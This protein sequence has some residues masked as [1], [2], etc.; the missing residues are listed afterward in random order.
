M[1][2]EEQKAFG[3]LGKRFYKD[4]IQPHV[5]H[6]NLIGDVNFPGNQARKTD[7]NYMEQYPFL[8][9]NIKNAKENTYLPNNKPRLD[10]NGFD[11]LRVNWLGKDYAYQIKNSA[12]DGTKNFHNIKPYELLEKDNKG[13]IENLLESYLKKGKK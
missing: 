2:K 12:Y 3:R 5:E 6:N 8:R 13:V 10:A 11:N 7:Y 4:N 9:Y 1:S